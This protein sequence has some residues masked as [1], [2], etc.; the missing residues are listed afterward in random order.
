MTPLAKRD[1]LVVFGGAGLLVLL[2]SLQLV[3]RPAL[4]RASTL[5]RVVA[6]KREVLV[7]MRA[8]SQEYKQ[9][10]A[11]VSQMRSSISGQ[12]ESRK[13]LSTIE[14]LRQAAKLPDDALSMKPTTTAIDKE[15]EETVVEISLDGT[16]LA[17]LVAFLSQLDSSDL[18]G[19]IKALDVGRANRDPGALRV[20]I[21]LATVARIERM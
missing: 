8:K 9:L 12:G 10:Q 19:G 20:T 21:Q 7:Q 2:L 1:K 18:A 16:T 6:E 15:Y 3:L 14:R 5:R 17:Q 13:I 11:E 4:E